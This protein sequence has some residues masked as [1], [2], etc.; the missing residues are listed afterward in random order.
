MDPLTLTRAIP[1]ALNT[2]QSLGSLFE[3][4]YN[5]PKQYQSNSKE[6]FKQ[7]GQLR[8][9]NKYDAPSHDQGGQM[10][11]DQGNVSPEGTNEIE[12]KESK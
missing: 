7:G 5:P 6:I 8:G 9:H 1:T 12:L 3:R 4:P 2:L 10:V 11:D